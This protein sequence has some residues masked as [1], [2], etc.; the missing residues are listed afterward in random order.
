MYEMNEDNNKISILMG[1]Y[2]CE[3]TL[4]RAIE[5]IFCQSYTEWELI[6]CDDAST[7]G[8]YQIAEYYQHRFPE[9]IIL[10]RNKENR[11]LAAALNRC[12]EYASGKYIARMDGD[13]EACPEK[14]EKQLQYL[15][16]HPEVDLVGTSAMRIYREKRFFL[17]AVEEPDRFTMRECI[18][19]FHA[20]ILTYRYVYDRVNGYTVSE[21]TRR[22]EDQDLWYK[23]FAAGFQGANLQEALYIIYETDNSIRK[24]KASDR[25]LTFRVVADGFQMLGYPRRW[26]IR[27]FMACLLRTLMPFGIQKAYRRLQHVVYGK[28]I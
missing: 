19:F 27:P 9:K 28:K 26:L 25:W 5:S 18:P 20:T 24:R 1:I 16:E 14:L 6:M 13:D 11:Y 10:L 12:L 4:P 3:S 23:F 21:R 17:K 2:N 8:T 22:A 15:K 7:D